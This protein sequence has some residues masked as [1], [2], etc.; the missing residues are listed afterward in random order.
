MVHDVF[1]KIS[2]KIDE[3]KSENEL[4]DSMSDGMI[5]E[6]KEDDLSLSAI[7]RQKIVSEE[8]STVFSEEV[9]VVKADNFR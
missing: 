8:S 2:L 7:D 1:T 9:P 4:E 6:S 3:N 5:E